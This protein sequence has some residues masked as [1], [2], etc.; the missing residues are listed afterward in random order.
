MQ[1]LHLIGMIRFMEF[2]ALNIRRKGVSR[3][4]TADI[5]LII[6]KSCMIGQNR[7]T[8]TKDNHG[9]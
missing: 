5:T 6:L 8:Q 3:L 1:T 7:R 9:D 2:A 4:H